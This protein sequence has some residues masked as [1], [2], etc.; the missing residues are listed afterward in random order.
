M[1]MTIVFGIATVVLGAALAIGLATHAQA[2]AP[3]NYSR[4]CTEIVPSV[5]ASDSV[6]EKAVLRGRPSFGSTHRSP[7]IPPAR[8]LNREDH[9]R[10]TRQVIKRVSSGCR[11][12]PQPPPKAVRLDF[13]DEALWQAR[14]SGVKK[15]AACHEANLRLRENN[16]AR[17]RYFLLPFAAVLISPLSTALILRSIARHPCPLS[18]SP[19][20]INRLAMQWALGPAE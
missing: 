4:A 13:I 17:R 19:R 14:G 16:G 7:D 9:G 12:G 1:R 6:V 8:L 3:A 2:A 5:V 10:R 15:R 11:R 20:P 18:P